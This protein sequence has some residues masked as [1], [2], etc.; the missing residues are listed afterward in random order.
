LLKTAAR[1]ADISGSRC[2]IS[3][4]ISEVCSNSLSR[5]VAPMPLVC[6]WAGKRLKVH[7]LKEANRTGRHLRMPSCQGTVV[8]KKSALGTRF[9]AH[10]RTGACG[11]EPKSRENLLAKEI[12]ARAALSVGWQVQSCEPMHPATQ[13]DESR[14]VPN[15]RCHVR[16]VSNNA[17]HTALHAPAGRAGDMSGGICN[18][19]RPFSLLFVSVQGTRPINTDRLRSRQSSLA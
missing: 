2:A 11:T 17:G 10:Q 19:Y 18:R 12:T 4:S 3:T 9:F 7:A 14:A 8:L 16:Q 5:A 6:A 13:P 1:P 15:L